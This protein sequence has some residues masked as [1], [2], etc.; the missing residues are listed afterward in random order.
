MRAPAT[1]PTTMRLE[2]KVTG[3]GEVVEIPVVYRLEVVPGALPGRTGSV[4]TRVVVDIEGTLALEAPLRV[5]LDE[6]AHDAEVGLVHPDDP[7][8]SAP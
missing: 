2:C 4:N 7:G 5:H 6:H 3:C 1:V 8:P